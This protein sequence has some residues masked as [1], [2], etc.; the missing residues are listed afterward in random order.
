MWVKAFG[1]RNGRPKEEKEFVR[2]E[3]SEG[4]IDVQVSKKVTPVYHEST[5]NEDEE[6]MMG[7][8]FDLEGNRY[9]ALT[10]NS[11]RTCPNMLSGAV[12]GGEFTVTEGWRC[13]DICSFLL[14]T[15]R[16]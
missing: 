15:S 8:I 9:C 1:T 14:A 16:V 10:G 6:T 12:P 7:L 11:Q 2:K 5:W 13:E 3:T 4:V